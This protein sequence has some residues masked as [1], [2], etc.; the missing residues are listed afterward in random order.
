MVSPCLPS[1]LALQDTV[2]KLVALQDM[3]NGAKAVDGQ[4][5]RSKYKSNKAHQKSETKNY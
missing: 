5:L 2:T 3:A 4:T 1:M